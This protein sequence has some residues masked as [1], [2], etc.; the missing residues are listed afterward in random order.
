[1]RGL[2]VRVGADQ[3]D[4]GGHWNGP[5][6]ST[7]RQ[8]VYVPIREDYS[9]RPEFHHFYDKMEPSLAQ[10]S[11][12][13]PPQLKGQRMHLD[14]DFSCLTYGDQGQRAKQIKDKLGAGDLI[15]FYAGLQ[16]VRTPH[17]LIYAIIGLYIIDTIVPAV[18]ISESD[19]DSNA[20]TRR[21]LSR[22]ADD[23]V[24]HARSGMS[25]RLSEYVEIG[26]FR[27]RAY[28]VKPALLKAWGGL[29]VKDGY[30]QRSAR[31][32]E[33][34]DAGL[35]YEWFLSCNAKLIANNN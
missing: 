18:A 31:L 29:S 1:M 3:S 14:P 30:L 24:V 27:E 4:A 23:I 17:H 12:H 2:L 26:E 34:L 6:D 21:I 19:W 32:P 28:R 8:F 15:V 33:F 11:C 5:C 20:H 9:V 7:T 13:L 16:D 22:S 10:L 35:F 25:G